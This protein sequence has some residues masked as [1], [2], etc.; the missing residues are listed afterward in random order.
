MAMHDSFIG[1]LAAVVGERYIVTDASEI[2]RSL[3]DNSWL[4]PLLSEHIDQRK[5]EE[6]KTLQVD[7]VVSPADAEQLS[8]VV[9]TAVRHN[10]PMT[11]RGGGTSNFGQVIPL[12]GGIILD[13][14]RINRIL[15]VGKD[16]ITVEA[17]ALQ[18]DVDAA[19]RAHGKEL[20]VLTTT[21]ASAT[22]AG[23][24][25]GGHV[26]L[27]ANSYGT[28]WDGNVLKVK[29]LTAEEMPRLL[30]LSGSDLLP[31][32]HT[33]GTTGV[34]TEVTFPL[35]E[36]KEWL[37]GVAVFDTFE[38]AVQFT[39]SMANE[40]TFAQR[41]VAAQEAPIAQ[42]FTPLLGLYEEGQSI[43]LMIVDATAEAE[44]MA[45]CAR[46]HG[47]WRRWRSA[48]ETG[49]IS[50]A[51]MVYGHR[52]LWVKKVAPDSAFLHGYFSPDA[53]FQQLQ[54]L[55]Q[56]FGTDVWL[57]YKYIKSRWLRALRGL[58][59]DGPLP[60]AV[61]TLLPTDKAF[62]RT[63]MEFCDSIG[64]SYLNPHTF[65]LEESGLFL[66]FQPIADFKRQSDPKGLLNPGKIGNKY[67]TPQETV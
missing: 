31:A 13:I 14:R 37:E 62:L 21:Y 38:A 64:V 55:K 50:L 60:A 47:T 9:A 36:A 19:A 24:V 32:L 67:F 54:A 65:L 59:G 30:E 26:G 53:Y 48:G 40:T 33:Y 66:D 49:K 20:T 18:G 17:G 11:V 29:M 42:G 63:V 56:R 2:S 46:Y 44:C 1:E 52:M 58:P 22:A 8:A 57:E 12:G 15:E 16:F 28:I 7:A 43:V 23:W 35:V 10:V 3:R 6:G 4:S 45:L 34:I 27:G 39:A 25:A 51:L 41:V 5:R 61:L